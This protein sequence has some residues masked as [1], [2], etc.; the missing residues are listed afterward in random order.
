MY[1]CATAASL[2]RRQPQHRVED[3]GEGGA[4]HAEPADESDA[5]VEQ[6]E[7]EQLR[8]H[9]QRD[10]ERRVAQLILMRN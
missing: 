1:R 8:G 9:E 6:R 4:E 2:R 7:R 10:A 5:G 3:G